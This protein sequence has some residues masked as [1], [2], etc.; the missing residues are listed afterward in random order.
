MKIIAVIPA[1]YESVRFP[2]KV[3]AKDTGKYLIQHTYEQVCRAELLEKVVIATDSK[4]VLDACGQ[5]GADCV[6]TA[7]THQSGTDRIAEAVEKIDAQ[8]IINV[9]GDEPEI[10]PANINLLA[11]LMLDNQNANMATLIAKFETAEQIANPNIVKVIIDKNRFAK[12]FS[13]A[14]IP[15]CRKTDGIGNIED[16]YRHLG[17]YAYRKEFLLRLTRLPAGKLENIEQLEQ[18]RVLEFGHN[19]LTGLVSAVADGIDTPQQYAEF[20]K[21]YNK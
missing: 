9:Q 16:Y 8:I 12:Y 17:I 10:E 2:G 14:V 15:Y 5:F 1:R 3:L 19:I 7:E 13:R 4:E 18:L 21:R 20:V 6:M 11:Q